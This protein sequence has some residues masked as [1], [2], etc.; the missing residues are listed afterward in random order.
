MAGQAGR[1]VVQHA[2][3]GPAQAGWRGHLPRRDRHSQ[4]DRAGRGAVRLCGTPPSLE[5]DELRL[6]HSGLRIDQAEFQATPLALQRGQVQ[7]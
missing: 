2:H 4:H 1:A 5:T 7:L 3:D 6:H